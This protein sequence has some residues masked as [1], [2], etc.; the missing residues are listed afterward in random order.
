[1]QGFLRRVH[2]YPVYLPSQVKSLY[3]CISSF[4]RSGSS[5]DP[6]ISIDLRKRAKS[7]PGTNIRFPVYGTVPEDPSPSRPGQTGLFSIPLELV[8][9]AM[10]SPLTS[11]PP[12]IISQTRRARRASA[13]EKVLEQLRGRDIQKNTST[14][15][16]VASP[17]T[18]WIN[19]RP[20]SIVQNPTTITMTKTVAATISGSSADAAVSSATQT[21]LSSSQ[22]SPTKRIGSKKSASRKQS[23]TV[24]PPS[25]I[26]SKHN[27]T[28]SR[29][30]RQ[31]SQLALT[32][33]SNPGPG[34][35]LAIPSGLLP[36]LD[37]EHHTDELSVKFEAGW[38]LL[39]QW[40]VTIGG[41]EGDGDFGRVV[42][43]YK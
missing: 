24:P 38:P 20:E 19:G 10:E 30:T 14:S 22:D 15:T 17:R 29:L 34:A 21:S 2:R 3:P 6:A 28:P 31:T 5:F 4:D 26:I 35:Q 37:G 18:S 40:L 16:A 39:E 41:G 33:S 36:L 1:M 27:L 12:V 8:P 32:N 7:P 13:A 23:P 11:A 43:I 42:I 9:G 25:P